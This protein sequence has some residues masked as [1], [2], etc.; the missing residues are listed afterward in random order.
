L[1]LICLFHSLGMF[2]D[3]NIFMDRIVSCNRA[4]EIILSMCVICKHV[5]YLRIIL[6]IHEIFI[7]FTVFKF[8][9]MSLIYAI[10]QHSFQGV[11]P[12]STSERI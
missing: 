8:M 10:L 1:M 5:I 9:S 4:L 12:D 3:F 2:I 7:Y 6:V 11:L